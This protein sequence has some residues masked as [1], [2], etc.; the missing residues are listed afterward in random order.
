MT[1]YK[2]K[3]KDAMANSR[4]W[5]QVYSNVYM[6]HK[7]KSNVVLQALVWNMAFV[8][9]N[10]LGSIICKAAYTV[11]IHCLG[12][13]G[14]KNLLCVLM[15]KGIRCFVSKQARRCFSHF[16]LVESDWGRLN[17]STLSYPLLCHC[18]SI[19][20]SCP[21]SILAAV[22]NWTVM[23]FFLRTIQ[24]LN[25]TH[26][27]QHS[28]Y[29]SPCIS[30]PYEDPAPLHYHQSFCTVGSLYNYSLAPTSSENQ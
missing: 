18:T 12:V 23:Y 17:S 4:V 13:R 21:G 25:P 15:G 22:T 9:L 1:T 8:T 3:A 20:N 11:D 19:T 30:I 7:A 16:G 28:L 27:T 24:T 2:Q 5:K 6:N 26:Y 29:P 14:R 10:H